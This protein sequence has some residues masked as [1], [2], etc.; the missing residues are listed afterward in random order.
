MEQVVLLNSDC[1]FL[2]TISWKRAMC[3]VVK[4]KV[5]VLKYSNK[6]IMTVDKTLKLFLPQVLRL[7]KLVRTF[8]K[9][10]VPF[11]KKNLLI[12]D[13]FVCQYCGKKSNTLTVDHIIPRSRG[14]QKTFENCVACCKPCNN[15]KQNRTPR[16]AHM[17]I[18]KKPYQPTIMEFLRIRMQLLGVHNL[19]K[20]LGVY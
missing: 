11:S 5:E 18:R 15:K 1:S 12:R 17:F 19:L 13:S 8:Y 9:R 20:E 2:N 7:I 6:T 3:L 16:E 4:N 14:G 10:K